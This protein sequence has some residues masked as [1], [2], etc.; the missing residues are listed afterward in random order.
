MP[1]D[2]QIPDAP[3][4]PSMLPRVSADDLTSHDVFILTQPGNNPGEKN[5]GLE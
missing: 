1:Y 2:R 4:A 3:V 5:K